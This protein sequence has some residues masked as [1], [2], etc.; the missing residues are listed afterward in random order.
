MEFHVKPNHIVSR[1]TRIL[2]KYDTQSSRDY[3]EK[4]ELRRHIESGACQ[5]AYTDSLI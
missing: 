5:S 4:V 1:I 2:A 3:S